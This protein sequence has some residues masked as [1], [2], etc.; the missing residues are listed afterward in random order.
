MSAEGRGKCRGKGQ[1]QREGVSAEGKG[2]CR[3]K[4]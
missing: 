2:E 4:G 3:G 1:V